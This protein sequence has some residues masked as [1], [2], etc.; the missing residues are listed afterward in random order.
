MPLM[1]FSTERVS[2]ESASMKSPSSRASPSAR[3]TIISRARTRCWRRCSTCIMNSPWRVYGRWEERY[4]GDVN[5]IVEVLF[6][7]LVK[8]S[9]K[10][11]WTGAGFTRIVMELADLPRHSAR[12]V[13]HRHKAAVEAWYTDLFAKA[14]VASPSERAREVALLV[15]GTTAPI[16]IH[17][18]RSYADAAARA[19]K[20]LIRNR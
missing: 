14:K 2:A 6:S 9:A 18:D 8:W 4:S 11:G 10:P 7:E 3:S 12:A 13:A 1:S 15:E 16:L 20:R 17:G 19:A 5:E